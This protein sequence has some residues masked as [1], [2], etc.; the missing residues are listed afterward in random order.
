MFRSTSEVPASIVFAR[1]RRNWYV[2]PSPPSTC[3]AGPAMST[4]DS[5][6]R[7]L[8]SDHMSLR[9]E[10]SG[11]GIP[12]R[13]MAV[14]ARYPF[15]CS[16]RASLVQQRGHRHGPAVAGLAKDLR[17]RHHNVLEE[18]LVELG[19]AGD[20]HEWPHL[21]AWALHVDQQ[22]GEA[23]ARVGLLALAG[24]E[25]APLGYVRQRRPHLLAV[26]DVVIAFV[27]GPGLQA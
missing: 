9:I 16:A 10:P 13:F 12:L 7:W 21:D 15:S 14:T 18:D 3:P 26:D 23:V 27:L 5:V 17:L 4:A 2:H 22:V 25:H 20:L 8:S 1:E 24:H 19:V 11:P 6:M